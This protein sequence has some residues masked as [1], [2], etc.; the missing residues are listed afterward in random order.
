MMAENPNSPATTRTGMARSLLN[1]IARHLSKLEKGGEESA[2]DLRSLPMTQ[3]DREELEELLGRGDVDVKLMAAGK[4]EIW[5]TR[6]CGVWWVRHFSGDGRIAAE[7]IEITSIPEIL[8]AH[9][10]DISA[11]SRKLEHEISAGQETRS[12]EEV[13]HG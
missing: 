4:S 13:R 5:E 10:S 2:I 3:P 11:A 12:K 7:T 8:I 9:R 1:E 6:F